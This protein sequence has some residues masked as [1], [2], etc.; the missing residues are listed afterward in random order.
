MC[1]R[2]RRRG[3]NG[4][5]RLWKREDGKNRAK[6]WKRK[7][8]WTPRR[9]RRRVRRVTARRPRTTVERR[10][11]AS[12]RGRTKGAK[13]RKRKSKQSLRRR[14]GP[15]RLSNNQLRRNEGKNQ[16]RTRREE[17]RGT[18]E[19]QDALRRYRG[20]RVG[21][22]SEGKRRREQGCVEQWV[23]QSKQGVTS[24]ESVIKNKRTLRSL[25]GTN[26]MDKNQVLEKVSYKGRR[27]KEQYWSQ[28][29][30]DRIQS[31]YWRGKRWRNGRTSRGY[32]IVDYRSGARV[33]KRNPRQ[34][35]RRRPR[36]IWIKR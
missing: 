13:R 23:W 17:R 10:S 25:H 2:R 16:V 12:R 30:K 1:K 22:L 3:W 7:G 35:E 5:R 34:G 15:L 26:D 24:L 8:K 29:K 4:G 18:L 9:V 20:G 21:S 32:T 33:V 6:W 31:Q 14:R 27:V 11:G 19:R 28:R 36:R